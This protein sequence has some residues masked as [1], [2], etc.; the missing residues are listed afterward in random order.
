MQQVSVEI[1]KSSKRKTLTEVS[2]DS[3]P[4]TGLKLLISEKWDFLQN[5][6]IKLTFW[7]LPFVRVSCENDSHPFQ[8]CRLQIEMLLIMRLWGLFLLLESFCRN[9]WWNEKLEVFWRM[10]KPFIKKM[11]V[12]RQAI[13]DFGANYDKVMESVNF[14]SCTQLV[15]TRARK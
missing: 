8:K 3:R 14:G 1:F 13:I 12:N 15:S 5:L 11:R 7:R 9:S 6:V 2:K 4:W 10:M